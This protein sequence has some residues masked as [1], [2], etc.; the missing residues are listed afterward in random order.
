[1]TGPVPRVMLV[2]DLAH[3]ARGQAAAGRPE[4]VVQ[5]RDRAASAR[6]VLAGARALVARGVRTIVNDRVDLAIAAG[7]AGVQLPE[8]GL[9]VEVARAQLGAGADVGV[10]LHVGS[11]LE[12]RA[13]GADWAL[14]GP[15]WE[16]PGKG[17]GA[18][19]VALADA[20]RRC[21]CPVLAVG[22]VD[23]GRVAAALGAGASGV[24]VIRAA[25]D[26]EALLAEART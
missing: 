12:V 26:L 2:L 23:R 3:L 5:V 25:D 13:R 15:V 24:A 1:M 9:P 22:G 10:S 19:L 17:A 4:V 6:D 8:E 21:P 11:R 7:A 18:G 16:S 14:F 20:A